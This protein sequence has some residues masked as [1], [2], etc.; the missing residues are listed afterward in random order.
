MSEGRKCLRN[1]ETIKD[2]LDFM[3]GKAESHTEYCH[4]TRLETIEKS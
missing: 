1:C 2:F 3:E 4:Y